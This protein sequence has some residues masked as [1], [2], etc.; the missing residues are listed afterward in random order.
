[1]RAPE[2]SVAPRS[3]VRLCCDPAGEEELPFKI[4]VLGDY[5]QRPHPRSLEER[6]AVTVDKDSFNQVLADHALALDLTVPDRLRAGAGRRL[7]PDA[8]H[9]RCG[10]ARPSSPEPHPRWSARHRKASSS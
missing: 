3:R 4:L 1:M 5:T 10:G 8:P 2:G 6:R 7:A 9:G